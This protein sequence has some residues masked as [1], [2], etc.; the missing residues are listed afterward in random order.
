MMAILQRNDVSLRMA[1]MVRLSE[2]EDERGLL[3]DRMNENE[4]G[5]SEKE[6]DHEDALLTSHRPH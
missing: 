5:T 3:C 2:D 4:N 6:H 1:R